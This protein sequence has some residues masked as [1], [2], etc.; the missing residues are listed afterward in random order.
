MSWRALL[1]IIKPS[2]LSFNNIIQCLCA[3][4]RGQKE[5]GR[6]VRNCCHGDYFWSRDK[7]HA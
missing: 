5:A 1:G 3:D 2:A 4:E 7:C 6:L